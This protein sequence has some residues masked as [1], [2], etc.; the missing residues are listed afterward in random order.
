M[1][2]FATL[3]NAL[4]SMDRHSATLP[5][6]RHLVAFLIQ[7]APFAALHHRSLALLPF[8]LH[9]LIFLRRPTAPH[10]ARPDAARDGWTVTAGGAS[11]PGRTDDRGAP[12]QGANDDAGAARDPAAA[13]GSGGWAGRRWRH[14]A[15]GGGL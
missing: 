15:G 11:T 13:D 2:F 10:T 4:P 14:N 6:C 5:V 7:A 3:P 12:G 9:F 8:L 1:N